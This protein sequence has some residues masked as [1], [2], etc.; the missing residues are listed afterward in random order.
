MATVLLA[1]V[2]VSLSYNLTAI[3]FSASFRL[4]H[5]SLGISSKTSSSPFILDLAGP[6]SPSL[7]LFLLGHFST[8]TLSN[9]CQQLGVGS[10]RKGLLWMGRLLRDTVKMEIGLKG[11]WSTTYPCK[12][13]KKK[14]SRI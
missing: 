11:V 14:H 1:I 12:A 2:G 6:Y 3:Y 5:S 10:P 7:R 13:T 4:L 9:G 8:E